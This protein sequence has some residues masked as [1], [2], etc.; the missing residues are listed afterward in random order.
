MGSCNPG[1]SAKFDVK[2]FVGLP[3]CVAVDINWSFWPALMKYFCCRR[4]AKTHF[5]MQTLFKVC[6]KHEYQGKL[7]LTLLL[8]PIF[9]FFFVVLTQLQKCPLIVKGLWVLALERPSTLKAIRQLENTSHRPLTQRRC[10]EKN[11][12]TPSHDLTPWCHH[13]PIPL[14]PSNQTALLVSIISN[15][16]FFSQCAADLLKRRGGR[17]MVHFH[18]LEIASCHAHQTTRPSA[19]AP[20]TQKKVNALP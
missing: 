6:D 2:Q 10:T 16:L 7:Q 18:W 19:H 15:F 12:I 14:M 3:I 17:L 11:R 1:I 5:G 20:N 8:P 4:R 13:P 9:F